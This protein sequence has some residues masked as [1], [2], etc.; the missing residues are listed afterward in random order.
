PTREIFRIKGRFRQRRME[1]GR[2]RQ[3]RMELEWR[4]ASPLYPRNFLSCPA[5]LVSP[6]YSRIRRSNSI[7]R[8]RKRPMLCCDNWIKMY[9]VG[10]DTK[11]HKHIKMLTFPD[12]ALYCN[13]NPECWYSRYLA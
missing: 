6:D 7:L 5:N 2:F 11:H 9:I 4:S 8:C 10:T 1:L 12:S 13:S 3:R